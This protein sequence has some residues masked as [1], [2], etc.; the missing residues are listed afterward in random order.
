[1]RRPIHL[2]TRGFTLIEL[3]ITLVIIGILALIAYPSY[4]AWILKS[5]RADAMSTLAQDQVILETCYSQT[6]TYNGACGALPT[7]PKTSPKG[8]YTITLT[9]QAATTYTLTATTTGTQTPDTHCTTMSIDQA[10]QQTATNT[11][12]WTP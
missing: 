10:N 4:T 12:C 1:M 6:F 3:M 11:D 7:F 5:H 8:Y 9:N 2:K